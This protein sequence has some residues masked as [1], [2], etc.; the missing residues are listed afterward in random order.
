MPR[1]I[2][3]KLIRDKIP[4]IIKINNAVSKISE[5]SAEE[6]KIALNKK[7]IEEACEL[8][9]AKSNEEILNEL[10]DIL[11]VTEAIAK[12]S[13]ITSGEITKRKEEKKQ[14]RGAFEKGLFLEYIDEE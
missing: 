3:N 2:Y 13:N 8:A 9:E 12:N 11:E 4:G 14:E 7:I 10:A 5:L 6:F 1:K